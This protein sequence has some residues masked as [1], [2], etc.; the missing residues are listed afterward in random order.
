MSGCAAQPEGAAR[1]ARQCVRICGFY[2][3]AADQRAGQVRARDSAKWGGQGSGGGGN[4]R[5]QGYARQARGR[6]TQDWQRRRSTACCCEK[7]WQRRRFAACCCCEVKSTASD[8]GSRRRPPWWRFS[9]RSRHVH[10]WAERVHGATASSG[11]AHGGGEER[12]RPKRARA[13][14]DETSGEE[15][16]R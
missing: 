16:A 7:K 4:A 15:G 3:C 2:T 10:W 5:S 8:V 9:R 11:H 1:G 6:H 14:R 12:Q 13:F